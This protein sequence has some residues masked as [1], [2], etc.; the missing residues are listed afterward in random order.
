MNYKTG[1]LGN[2]LDTTKF[3]THA[4][5]DGFT[6][7]VKII[8][9]K[10]ENAAIGWCVFAICA[11][12]LA[13]TLQ[14]EPLANLPTTPGKLPKDVVTGCIPLRLVTPFGW[15]RAVGDRISPTAR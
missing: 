5:R 8:K 9:V 7:K 2:S 4:E 10:V 14:A 3:S 15:L 12:L 1:R 11:L 13:V 6:K